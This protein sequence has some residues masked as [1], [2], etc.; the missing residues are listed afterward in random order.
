ME[1][2]IGYKVVRVEGDK[3]VSTWADGV[4]KKEYHVGEWTHEVHEQLP[5]CLYVSVDAAN[6]K[7]V[8]D[9]SKIHRLFKCEYVLSRKRKLKFCAVSHSDETVQGVLKYQKETG[10][11]LVNDSS[12][13]VLAKSIKLIE[14]VKI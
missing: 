10:R 11:P 8:L 3:L 2:K 5:L 13:I 9:G 12:D 6:S 1:T 7:F 14:E 4:F